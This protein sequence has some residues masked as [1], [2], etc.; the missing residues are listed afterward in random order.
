MVIDHVNVLLAGHQYFLMTLIGRGTFPLFCYAVAAAI[1]KIVQ[2]PGAVGEHKKAVR[3]Y[4]LR[5]LLLALLTQPVYA[6]AVDPYVMN[7]IVTLALGALFTAY[8]A[9]RPFRHMVFLYG[10]ALV[11]MLWIVPVEFGLAGVML[12]SAI[13]LV[14][15]GEARAWPFL[16]LLLLFI[17]LGGL[18]EIL[19]DGLTTAE[20]LMPLLNG[21]FAIALPWAVLDMARNMRQDGRLLSKY[22]LHVFYPGHLLLLKLIALMTAQ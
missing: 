2:R 10:V 22:A 4:V 19:H 14:R 18:R 7:V 5:L 20:W 8:A 12:P 16:V 11:S 17:N 13:L 1:L 9:W 21:V 6:W 3:R 15:K